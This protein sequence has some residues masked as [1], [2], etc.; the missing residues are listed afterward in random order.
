M[1]NDDCGFLLQNQ[2][3]HLTYEFFR[4]CL[5][6][7]ELQRTY[8]WKNCSHCLSGQTCRAANLAQQV[9]THIAYNIRFQ[10][11]C[12]TFFLA[13]HIAMLHVVQ[14]SIVLLLTSCHYIAQLGHLQL[15]VYC[16]YRFFNKFLAV[17]ADGIGILMIDASPKL[18]KL[19]LHE[20]VVELVV[21]RCCL[22]AIVIHV[23]Q[24]ARVVDALNQLHHR[25]AHWLQLVC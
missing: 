25:I 9:I 23:L 18:L 16:A 6:H 13:H 2:T 20:V 17:K 11:L 15:F 3:C 7:A 14:C 8:L 21:G 1:F 19:L 5:I 10:L 4:V 24:Y 22:A 12:C